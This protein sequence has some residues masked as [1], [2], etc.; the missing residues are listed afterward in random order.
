GP[1]GI[2][3][4][5]FFAQ[6][7]QL[8]L[9]G[10]NPELRAR[11]TVDAL[12]ALADLGRIEEET[13]DALTDAYRAHRTLEH[14][15]QMIA[16]QQ[17]HAMPT[18]AEA[19]DQV[20]ALGGW[21]DR[22]AMEEET[23]VRLAD[24]RARV[25]AFFGGAKPTPPKPVE[26]SEDAFKRPDLIREM[27]DRWSQGGV[28]ATRDQR[29]RRKFRALAPAVLARLAAAGD[30]DDAALHF[31][32]FISGLPAGVQL[33]SLFEANPMLLDLLGE[34]CAASP[35]LAEYLGRNARV[36]DAVLDRDFFAPLPGLE[37]LGADLGASLAGTGDY[38]TVLDGV[39]IW[40]REQHFRL[41]VQVLRGVADEREAGRAFTAIAEACLA[42]LKPA[43]EAEFARRHGSPPGRGAVVIGMGK[44]GSAEMTASSDLDLIVV[45]DAGEAEASDGPKP[46][47][48][49][50]YYAR[51]T[52]MLVS[53]LTTPTAEGTLY[54]VD[55]RL[56]PSGGQGPVAVS[57]DSFRHYQMNEAW[58]W[59]HMALTRARPL[60]GEASLMAEV[61]E[62]I[63]TVLSA[64]RDPAKTRADVA[65]MR[66]RLAADGREVALDPGELPP[67]PAPVIAAARAARAA[68]GDAADLRP[69]S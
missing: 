26:T 35:K 7:Q 21:P 65:E 63:E 31:D 36:L 15:L 42:A 60:A 27:V 46:L 3:E 44:M 37:A 29:A 17:T 47:S 13:R 64:P 10:R 67:D 69:A 9:G 34:I 50:Q 45:Y 12:A 25:T 54:E 11:R 66:G 55:M 6:T 28:A 40:A 32:R 8:A 56:R 38:E 20:A 23:T 48:I 33:F 14:R 41:G 24:V 51:L 52:K 49:Q 62:I 59:E 16:D 5:E 19:R 18:G 22:A 4:I 30:P 43:V 1:G 39:R 53:A 58:T 2:R 61:A 57:L 68:R